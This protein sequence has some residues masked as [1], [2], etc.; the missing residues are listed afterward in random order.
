[1]SKAKEPS[2]KVLRGGKTI[3]KEENQ[4]KRSMEAKGKRISWRK[5]SIVSKAV[6]RSR[7]TEEFIGFRY[8]RSFMGNPCH[9]RFRKR[10]V[11]E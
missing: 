4:S 8:H 11:V 5:W 6:E 10:K 1:M 3:K 2:K 9:G 7:K